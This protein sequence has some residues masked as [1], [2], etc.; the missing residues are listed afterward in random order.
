MSEW[1]T[2]RIEHRCSGCTEWECIDEVY[3][4]SDS[5]T[6]V[7]DAYRYYNRHMRNGGEGEYRAIKVEDHTHQPRKTISRD[8]ASP[9]ARQLWEA[10]RDVNSNESGWEICERFLDLARLEGQRNV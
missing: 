9:L 5:A 10:I 2:Y 1:H 7:A 3:D 6:Y 8:E 4:R